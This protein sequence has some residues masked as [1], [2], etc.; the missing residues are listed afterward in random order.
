MLGGWRI[1]RNSVEWCSRR[2][3]ARHNRGQSSRRRALKPAAIA[4]SASSSH[5]IDYKFD[6]TVSSAMPTYVLF[7][8]DVNKCM[9]KVLE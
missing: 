9:V 4:M 2:E 1:H 6:Y 7:A 8:Q 3:P 5:V